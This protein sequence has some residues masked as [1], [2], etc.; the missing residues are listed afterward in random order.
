MA[1]ALLDHSTDDSNL[2]TFKASD[3]IIVHSQDVGT[4]GFWGGTV[5]CSVMHHYLVKL[6]LIVYLQLNGKVGYFPNEYV[7]VIKKFSDKVPDKIVPTL[8][9]HHTFMSFGT[10]RIYAF[11]LIHHPTA[12][13]C[14]GFAIRSECINTF[15]ECCGNFIHVGNLIVGNRSN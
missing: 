15:E 7:K 3:E 2:L 6:M 5:S 11:F 4:D 8:V 14:Q 12:I 10:L 13:R 9:R 1:Q